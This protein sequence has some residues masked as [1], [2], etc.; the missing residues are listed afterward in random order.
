LLKVKGFKYPSTLPLIWEICRKNSNIF[1]MRRLKYIC[2]LNFKKNGTVLY[3][4][5]W[6]LNSNNSKSRDVRTFSIAYSFFSSDSEKEWIMKKF[7]F[8][9]LHFFQWRVQVTITPRNRVCGLRDLCIC[10]PLLI[11]S[12]NIWLKFKNFCPFLFT[13]T[14]NLCIYRLRG[15]FESETWALA[16]MN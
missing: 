9:K 15:R 6:N 12:P 14:Q 5:I 4:K 1:E 11:R 13:R 10:D 16:Q 8:P 7:W 2:I 3:V